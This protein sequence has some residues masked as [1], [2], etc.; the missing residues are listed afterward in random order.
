[1]T[2]HIAFL[3]AINVGGRNVKMDRLREIFESMGFSNVETFIASGNVI[4][5]SKSKD[6]DG[7][8][9]KIEK[10]LNESLG[11]EVATFIRSDSELAGIADYKP[12]PKS[13]M[14][15]AAALN[16]AFLAQPLDT[17]SKKLLMTLKTDIDDF[18]VHGQEVYW[19]CLK[20][21][22]ESKFSNAIF[23]KTLGVKST[24]RGINTIKKMA[25][26]YTA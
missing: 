23:E 22:S 24:F 19:L 6:V 8:V 2:K 17:K 5:E 21:Q 13:Q 25:Y 20:K 7:L 16:V 12:F 18:H 3:R 10:G 26:K 15:S 9:K 4:F 1:M 14:D 11:F